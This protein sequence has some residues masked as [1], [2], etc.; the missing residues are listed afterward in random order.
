MSSILSL[1]LRAE[2]YQY[3]AL[4][5]QVRYLSQFADQETRMLLPMDIPILELTNL[6]TMLRTAGTLPFALDREFK[7]HFYQIFI[8]D[9]MIY[10]HYKLDS[11]VEHALIRY[12][13]SK[14][15]DFRKIRGQSP[16]NGAVILQ[17]PQAFDKRQRERMER[18][19]EAFSIPII[20]PMLN[21]TAKN[22]EKFGFS[23]IV[24]I[25]TLAP[26]GLESQVQAKVKSLIPKE[27]WI[28]QV[29]AASN[30]RL[31]TEVGEILPTDLGGLNISASGSESLDM[32]QIQDNL[33][34][35]AG[36]DA[37]N[38]KI[39]SETD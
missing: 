34:R 36:Y 11:D 4:L 2:Q 23:D 32:E 9:V 5:M 21:L 16:D 20:L 1:G 12:I 14:G 31:D 35:L 13:R 8:D 15:G 18:N 26:E 10:L 27:G 7:I 25:E 17:L 24:G 33:S 22:G 3:L 39:K 30:V 29:E 37:R 19:F 38:S 28:D 6:E